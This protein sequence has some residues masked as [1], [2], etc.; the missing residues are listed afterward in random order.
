[1]GELEHRGRSVLLL[2]DAVDD[3]FRRSDADEDVPRAGDSVVRV[4][5][6]SGART[7]AGGDVVQSAGDAAAV[8]VPTD[9]G[10]LEADGGLRAM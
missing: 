1:M 6:V 9:G 8:E 2:C 7:G 5:R 10:A 3:R 4:L